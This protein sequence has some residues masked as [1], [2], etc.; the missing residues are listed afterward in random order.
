MASTTP[1]VRSKRR[2]VLT[3]LLAAGLLLCLGLAIA[4]RT[5]PG[6][7][8]LNVADYKLRSAWWSVAGKPQFDPS[9]TG[10]IV[11]VI[12]DTAGQPIAEA[13]ALVATVE[14]KTFQA[15]SDARGRYRIDGV[16]PGRYVPM[17]A[18]WGYDEQNGPSLQVRAGE[19]QSD[20]DLRLA[21]HEV[22]P[23]TPTNLQIGQR[24]QATTEFPE[25]LFATRI[26]FTFTLDGL[27]INNGQIYLPAQSP[28]ARSETGQSSEGQTLEGVGDS[29]SSPT[30]PTPPAFPNPPT[31]VIIYP[32]HPL[33]W[34]AASVALTRDGNPVLAL[35]PDGDRALD[36][37]GHVRDFRAALQLWREG[38][39][40]LLPFEPDNWVLM[41]G[42][43]GSLIMFRALRD[44]PATP[45]AI[46][47]V[48]GVSDAFLGIQALYADREALKIPPPYDSAIAAMGR[49]DR[50]PAF[51]FGYS[52]VFSAS[53]LPPM[54]VIH[55]YNDEV[56]PYTQGEAMA[57]ALAAAGV[58]HDLLLYEDTTH[59]LDA[60]NPTPG[61]ELVYE[62][63]LKY[64]QEAVAGM[65]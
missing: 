55:T 18:A 49:P 19:Q 21:L 15:R 8:A 14:G 9:Q 48:G 41:S 53:K 64:V 30:F 35:G 47:N 25:P 62:R 58:P 51:F 57:A 2:I 24:W 59:Y 42:S 60:Y 31:L 5:Q 50:D 61:T 52:P 54:F 13:V 7:A 29:A 33:N 40:T 34:N 65:R 26:P 6:Q 56:I 11:G 32:S 36:I 12:Q 23:I 46:V 63:V 10:S 22:G 39:L 16:P 3:V 20:V 4:S 45:P 17:A 27:S 38:D 43:F 37:E 28:E 1:H 44:L